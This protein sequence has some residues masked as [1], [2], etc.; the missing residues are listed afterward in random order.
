LVD[1]GISILQYVDDMMVFMDHN[2]EHA[3]NVKLFLTTF[4]HML[5]LKIIFH[6][7]K[8]YCYGL[9]KEREDHYSRLFRC[10]IGLM[11]FTYLRIPMTHRR[12]RNSE[13]RCVID[14]FKKRLSN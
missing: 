13:W 5:V 12:L 8:L 10:G 3:H 4:E 11:P 14:R 6:K 9:A 1:G 7:I 2:L